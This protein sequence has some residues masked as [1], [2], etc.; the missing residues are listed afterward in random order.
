MEVKTIPYILTTYIIR[1]EG[2]FSRFSKFK[3]V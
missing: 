1:L 3:T 2:P